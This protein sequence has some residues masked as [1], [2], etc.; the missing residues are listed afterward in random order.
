MNQEM[1]MVKNKGSSLRGLLSELS[2][3]KELCSEPLLDSF[4]Y[5]LIFEVSESIYSGLEI[6]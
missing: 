1:A 3:M 2:M 5:I 6:T 4:C